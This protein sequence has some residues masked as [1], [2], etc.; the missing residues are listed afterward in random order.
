MSESKKNFPAQVSE[1]P[2]PSA[3]DTETYERIVSSIEGSSTSIHNRQGLDDCRQSVS[4]L[5]D[6]LKDSKGF[7][8]TVSIIATLRREHQIL[9]SIR[10]SSFDDAKHVR[11]MRAKIVSTVLWAVIGVY[12]FF[13]AL[14]VYGLW[15]KLLEVPEAFKGWAIPVGAGG[16][17]GLLTIIGHYF[18]ERAKTGSRAKP[19][20]EKDS[21]LS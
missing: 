1:Q 13:A 17:V 7:W 12:V 15:S 20:A 11:R 2:H 9:V 4:Q 21:Q 8:S 18:Q 3:E 14:T 10:K 5:L 16:G 6:R 19:Q